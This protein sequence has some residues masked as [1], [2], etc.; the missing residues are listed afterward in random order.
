MTLSDAMLD[1]ARQTESTLDD[2]LTPEAATNHHKLILAMR[3]SVMLPGKRIRPYLV[4]EFCRLH[5]GD[6][7]KAVRY[8]AAIEMLHTMSLIHDDLPAMD[9]DALRRGKPSNHVVF[10][11]ATAILAGDALLCEAFKAAAD[12]TFCSPKQNISAV[13][14]LAEF[15]GADGMMGGQQIDLQSEKMSVP[16]PVL[17]DLVS[18]KTAS[19]L[20]CS[21]LLGCI[22][23]DASKAEKNRAVDFGQKIGKV[24]QITDDILDLRGDQKL[25]GKSIGKDAKN[26]KSTYVSL[27]GEEKAKKL[28]CELTEQAKEALLVYADSDSGKRLLELCDL[29]LS[30]DR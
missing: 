21:C 2:I 27:L 24:F 8:A 18:K 25:L 15:G 9:N 3:Y 23:A 13:N 5:G 22:A 29:L 30:R 1:A 14:A 28:A 10:G 11:E 7:Q 12:N 20:S 6:P 19:L 16:L 17:D 26:G 4:I